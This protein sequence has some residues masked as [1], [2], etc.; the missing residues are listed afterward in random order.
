MQSNNVLSE[1]AS[2]QF[3]IALNDLTVQ[4]IAMV[5]LGTIYTKKT[6]H[7]SSG[8]LVL[9]PKTVDFVLNCNEIVLLHGSG[10]TLS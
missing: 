5:H 2:R 7:I 10:V 4:V 8:F 6:L 9:S 1:D 3:T